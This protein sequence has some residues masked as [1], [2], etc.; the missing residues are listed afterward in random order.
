MLTFNNT[1]ATAAHFFLNHVI[2]CFD[3]PKQLVSDHGSHFED[4]MWHELASHLGFVHEFSSM[5]Y[6]QGNGQVEVVNKILKTMLQRIVNKHKT[7]WHHMLFPALWAYRTSVKTATGFTPFH[8]VHGIE[9]VLPIECEI[10]SLHLAIELLP[11]TIVL[12]QRL[13]TLEQADKDCHITLQCNEAAKKHSKA[14]Y[15]RQVHPRSF[16]EGDLILAYDQVLDKLGKGK[17][18]SLWQGPFIIKC[19]LRKGGISTCLP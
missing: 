3:V 13:I 6:S 19:C 17:F 2:T 7:N 9:E 10:P 12:E 4:N 14:Q 16:H 1:T 15:D 5:Y 11:D 18:E 8:L